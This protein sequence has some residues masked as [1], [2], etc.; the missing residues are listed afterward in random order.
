MGVLRC[1]RLGKHFVPLKEE[2]QF[3]DNHFGVEN[4]QVGQQIFFT[5]TFLLGLFVILTLYNF[6]YSLLAYKLDFGVVALACIGS[7]LWVARRQP[8]LQFVVLLNQIGFN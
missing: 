8:L 3:D 7:L 4:S 5:S 6:F 2:N 1:V